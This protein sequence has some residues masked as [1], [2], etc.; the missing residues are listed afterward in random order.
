MKDKYP[1]QEEKVGSPVQYLST[2]VR[3]KPN[4]KKSVKNINKKKQ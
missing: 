2:N 4:Q 3:E 1:V